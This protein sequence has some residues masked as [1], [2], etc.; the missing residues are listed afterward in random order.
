MTLQLHSDANGVRFFL[1]NKPVNAGDLLALN[2]G[3]K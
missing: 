1:N 3:G 2:Y